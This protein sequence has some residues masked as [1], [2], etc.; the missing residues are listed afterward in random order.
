M[1]YLPF[2]L[3]YVAKQWVKNGIYIGLFYFIMIVIIEFDFVDTTCCFLFLIYIW[4]VFNDS[5]GGGGGI[6]TQVQY[7]V[8][9]G[10]TEV[11]QILDDYRLKPIRQV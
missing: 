1:V 7:N 8:T 5:G 9:T 4:K 10:Q 11:V 6:R 3:K 2:C